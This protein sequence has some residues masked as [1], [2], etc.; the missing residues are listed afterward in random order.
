M[1]FATG[2]TSETFTVATLQ[3]SIDETDET[4]TVT[5]SS[6]SPASAAS[7]PA[8]VTAT[9]TIID[10]DSSSVLS[11]ADASADEG[12]SATFTVT[13]NPAV[14][15]EVTVDY[16]TSVETGDTA[17]QADFTANNGTLTFDAG[18][19][20]KTFTVA[21][22]E[23]SVDEVDETFTVTLSSASGANLASDATATGT[24]TDDDQST[25][26]IAD[27]SA[28]EGDDITFTV[29]LD[30]VSSR[31]EAVEY[32]TVAGVRRHGRAGGLRGELRDAGL[33]GGGQL[34]NLHGGDHGGHRHRTGRDLHGVSG[35]GHGHRPDG[36]R[37][38]DRHHPQRRSGGPR[39]R[40]RG[41]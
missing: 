33:R 35:Q 21:T 12:D 27:A 24:I 32:E 41:C 18:D 40:G 19:T 36:G 25:L 34:A 23:D 14:T 13:L 8:D 20:T 22:L 28:D 10:D 11:I 9:G 30:P 39:H 5:L 16:A 6:V 38:G 4:F 17:A 37:H 7:L 15:A 3:D 1:T 26:S 29:T 31:M 2:D